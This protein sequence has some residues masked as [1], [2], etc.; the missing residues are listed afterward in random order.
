MN[1]FLNPWQRL[2][3]VSA[4]AISLA[5][6]YEKYEN[7]DSIGLI[8]VT[9]AILLAIAMS[10]PIPG[11]DWLPKPPP[12][13]KWLWRHKRKVTL[14][15]CVLALSVAAILHKKNIDEIK[16]Q[17]DF[18][19]EQVRENLAYQQR[20]LAAEKDYKKCIKD[21]HIQDD[22]ASKGYNGILYA[23]LQLNCR[24]EFSKINSQMDYAN[25]EKLDADALKGYHKPKSE[26]KGDAPKLGQ[27]PHNPDGADN[28]P[29]P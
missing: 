17:N 8:F 13:H 29:D 7:D 1:F 3:I 15:S 18:K 24:D 4:A 5:H 22:K 14:I 21:A 10:K 23:Y 25:F 19:A 27:N 20:L 11:Q 6:A 9:G 16:R 12:I 28:S 2:I 26:K